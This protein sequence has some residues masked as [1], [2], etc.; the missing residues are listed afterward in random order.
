MKGD[1]NIWKVCVVQNQYFM[2]KSPTEVQNRPLVTMQVPTQKGDAFAGVFTSHITVSL[3]ETS[4]RYCVIQT[5][6]L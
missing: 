6:F 2:G 1:D 5:S 3:Q 4:I